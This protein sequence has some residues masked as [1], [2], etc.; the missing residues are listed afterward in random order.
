MQFLSFEFAAALAVVLALYWSVEQAQNAI[1][2]AASVIFVAL[3]GWSAVTLLLVS[4]VAEWQIALAVERSAEPALRKRWLWV[5]VSLNLSQLIYFKYNQFYVDTLATWAQAAHLPAGALAVAM[6]VGLSFWTLQKMTLTLDVYYR[7][8]AAERNLLRCI[9]FVAFFPTLLS[10]PIERASRFLPQLSVPR[11]WNYS[12][13]CQGIWLLSLGALHKCVLADQVG[14]CAEAWLAPEQSGLATLLGLWAYA[15]QIYGDFAG[16]SYM[17]RGVAR[18]FGL[19]VT[20]NFLAPYL[21][22]NLSDFWKHWHVSLSSWLN[23][24]IFN[25][26]ALALRQRPTL[27]VLAAAWATFL[28]SGLWHGTGWQYVVWGAIHSAGISAVLLSKNLRKRAKKRLGDPLWLRLLA[29]LVSFHTVCL[30]YLFFRSADVQSGW[31]QLC[32]LFSGPWLPVA[33][34]TNAWLL[35]A[36]AAGTVWLQGRARQASN[37][38]WVF[39]LSPWRRAVVYAALMAL[40]LRGYAPGERFIYFQF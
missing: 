38:F 31:A 34:G 26:L 15:L 20:Q 29:G 3:F 22:T 36:A 23:D 9:T 27:G 25:P 16:Y 24:F 8:M 37:L 19:D 7:R 5:S 32:G 18:L 14:Q 2:L 6:P 40:L 1:L 28:T 4:T 39:D 13:W 35:A 21:T 12:V 17:A 10:G 11:R 33:L 30:G